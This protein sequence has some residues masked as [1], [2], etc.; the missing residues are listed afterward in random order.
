MAVLIAGVAR[1]DGP[2]ERR[3]V[4]R[5]EIAALA[6]SHLRILQL[7]L[8][9]RGLHGYGN[10]S[11]RGSDRPRNIILNSVLRLAHDFFVAPDGGRAVVGHANQIHITGAATFGL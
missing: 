7:L 3:I 5:S 6:V 9:G 2:E 8:P 10:R 4:Q 1:L 11:R